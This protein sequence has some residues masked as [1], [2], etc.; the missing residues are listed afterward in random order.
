MRQHIRKSIAAGTR[1]KQTR[2]PVPGFVQQCRRPLWRDAAF[3][4]GHISR[5]EVL[6]YRFS[7][8]GHLQLMK[9]S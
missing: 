4:V 3:R 8:N 9:V 6:L 1:T 7:A 2:S 5:K